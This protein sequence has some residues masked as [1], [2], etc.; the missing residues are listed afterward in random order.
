ME[1][2][3]KNKILEQELL[4]HMEALRTFAFHLTYDE[5]IVDDLVQE[6]YLKA[7]KFLKG[8]DEGTNGKAWLFMI[9]KNTFI[10]EYRKKKRIPPS[11]D[12]STVSSLALGKDELSSRI[13]DNALGDEVTIALNSLPFEYKT[14]IL[15][16]DIEHFTYEEISVITE[17][18]IGTVR[19]R[20][21]RGRNMLKQKLQKYAEN[22]GYKDY[23]GSKNEDK[24]SGINN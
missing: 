17:Q 5:S 12:L 21:F 16:C 18:P 6:T 3:I 2:R 15:L 1:D 20:L 10:N 14:V 22:L 24:Q 4:P 9:L 8:Y 19:S 11:V 7:Y 23:R 13:F